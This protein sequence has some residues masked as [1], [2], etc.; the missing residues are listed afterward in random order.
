[1]Y[2]LGDRQDER[3]RDAIAN[4]VR[5]ASHFVHPDGS[6]GGEYT[7]RNTYNYFPHGFELVGR[8][9]PEA[10]SINDRFLKGLKNGCGS[11]YADDHIV[12][13]HTWNYLPTC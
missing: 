10:L 6:Y 12:G 2:D 11:C 7:S 4:G 9:L 8:W 5:L 3:L 13:H 1:M